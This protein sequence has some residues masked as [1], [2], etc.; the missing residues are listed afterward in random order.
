LPENHGCPNLFLSRHWSRHVKSALLHVIS[1]ARLACVHTWAWAAGSLDT[2][3]RLAAQLQQAQAEIALLREE[4]RIKNARMA[5]IPAHRRPHYPPT[6]RMAILELRAARGWNQVQTAKAML[7]TPETVA[8]WN[9]RVDEQGPHALVQLPEPVNRFHD[10]VRYIVRRLKA[11]CPTLG[12]VGIARI[13]ARAGLH[14]AATTVGQIMKGEPPCPDQ[15]TTASEDMP[16]IEAAAPRVVT[17]KYPNHV[18]H[19]DLTAV[20][21]AG[22]WVPWLPFALP[23]VWPFCWW[24]AVGIDHFSRRV[25]G[26]AAF[27][28]PPTFRQ[29]AAFL[30][31]TI[32]K[33]GAKPKYIICDKGVQFW[34]NAFKCWCKPRGIRPRFGAVGKHGSLAVIERFI[35]SMKEEGLRRLLIPLRQRA[36]LQEASFYTT[37]YNEH[38]PHTALRGATP[39]E[40]YFGLRPANRAPRFEPRPHWPR[41]SPCTKPQTLIMG[42]PG[43][44]I[45]LAVTFEAGRRHLPV[46]TLRRV[47]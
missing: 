43:A 5:Q 22:F 11:L 7:V 47:A 27:K 10:F 23:Q 21:I 25:M 28:R 29:V 16:G 2:R 19:V 26:V 17:A 18:W 36:F 1:L 41:G 38:R 33:T 30:R 31:R 8:A 44:R 42:Q 34:C 24:V 4:L 14:L 3:T 20:P 37:W 12:K 39:N 46:V 13:L 6:E 35:R 32:R 9:R 40:R 45:E 15:T